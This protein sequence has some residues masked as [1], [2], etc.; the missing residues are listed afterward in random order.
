MANVPGSARFTG[1]AGVLTL[2]AALGIASDSSAVML[3]VSCK[4]ASAGS[5]KL[6]LV[7]GVDM[8]MVDYPTYN[9]KMMPGGTVAG[10]GA[11][12][13]S[14]GCGTT[15]IMLSPDGKA[16]LWA[17]PQALDSFQVT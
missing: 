5:V 11:I 7:S 2:G 13:P 4:A 6:R 10:G 9:T 16:L 8:T 3:Q 17:S 15:G 14:S 1:V 12:A